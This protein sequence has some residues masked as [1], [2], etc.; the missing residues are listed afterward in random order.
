MSLEDFQLLDNEPFDNSIIKRDFLK[1]YHQQ[2]AQLNT[3]DQNIEFI[4]GENNNYHQIG[5]AYPEFDITVRRNDDVDFGDNDSIRMT[6]NAF[7][8]VFK[9]GRVI[10]TSGGDLEHNKFVG[11]ILTIVRSLTSHDGDLLSQFDNMN[12]KVVLNNDGTQNDVDTSEIITNTSLKKMFIDNHNIVGQEFNRGKIKGQL[13]LD[14]IFRFCKTF[15]KI[16]KN[17]EFHITFKTANLQDIIYTTIAD[18]AANQINVTI[19]SLYLYVPYLIPSTETQL[20]FNESIQNNYRI[21][22]DEWRTERRIVRDQTYQV[23]IGSAQSVNSPKYLI[24]AHQTAARSNIPNKRNN[25]SIFDNLNV[26]KYFIEIDGQRYPRDSVLTKYA[27]NDYID[28]YRDLKIFYKEYVGEELLSPFIS[29]PDMKDKYPIRVIDLRFQP[30]HITPKKIQL[31]EEYRANPDSARLY[32][33]L[34]RRREIEFI[35]DGNKLIEVK[36]I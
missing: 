14:H 13:Q 21:F 18:N 20:M 17:L 4:F 9:E 26:R 25:I 33:I 5:N 24:C 31:F 36:V 34:I 11:Q 35:S 16:T 1:V 29:Y 22:F 7:G 10:T 15:K 12:E 3:S 2:G 28:Q 8:F 19:N 23:D 6:N 32:V 27:E 30:D